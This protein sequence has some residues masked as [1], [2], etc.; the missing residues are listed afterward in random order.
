[1]ARL[2]LVPLCPTLAL[3]GRNTLQMPLRSLNLGY[4]Q[5]KVRLV[6][7]LK[8][9]SDSLHTKCKGP[10][11]DRAHVEGRTGGRT[12]CQPAKTSGDSWTVSTR[13]SGTCKV[14]SWASK[15]ERKELVVSE[16]TRIEDDMYKISAVS[17]QQQGR[18]TNWETV[19]NRAITWADMW[20]ILQ[21]RLSFLNT[22]TFNIL[23][24]PRNFCDM[25]WK[26]AAISVTPKTP[27][28]STS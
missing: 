1:M 16:V 7:A 11:L 26:Q 18:W 4:R 5:E 20:K 15:N 25:G 19:T 2:S 17:Q 12:S 3:F 21:A 13:Q 28:C 22:L 27:V 24:S 6:F 23:P 9:S 8:D 10:T 14:W